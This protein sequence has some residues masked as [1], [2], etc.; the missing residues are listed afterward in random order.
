VLERIAEHQTLHHKLP[1]ILSATAA[2]AVT[3]GESK[4]A[5]GHSKVHIH[6]PGFAAPSDATGLGVFNSSVDFGINL[7]EA[8]LQHAGMP[9]LYSS[10]FQTLQMQPN[11][12]MSST[13]TVKTRSS[14]SRTNKDGDSMSSTSGHTNMSTSSKSSSRKTSP[15]NSSNNSY[16]SNGKL[17]SSIMHSSI[18]SGTGSTPFNDIVEPSFTVTGLSDHPNNQKNSI[19]TAGQQLYLQQQPQQ[20]PYYSYPLTQSQFKDPG[21]SSS[22]SNSNNSDR[23]TSGSGGTSRDSSMPEEGESRKTKVLDEEYGGGILRSNTSVDQLM[24]YMSNGSM[25]SIGSDLKFSTNDMGMGDDGF[26]DITFDEDLLSY[27][28]AE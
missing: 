28:I 14:G 17:S 12:A 5:G 10:Q 6:N 4:S 8:Q 20:Q 15:R 22:K 3:E 2:V 1:S 9:P 21:N 26:E 24:R 23:S 13:M 7:T 11:V 16:N 18:V 19:R 25:E 27:P